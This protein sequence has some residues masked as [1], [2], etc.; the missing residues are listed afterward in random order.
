MLEQLKIFIVLFILV[1]IIDIPVISI[2]FKPRWDK[3][4]KDI[5]GTSL[6]VNMVYAFI[7]YILIPLGLLIFVYPKIDDNKWLEQ[8]IL[9]GFLWGVITYG[10]FD[11]TN[12]GLLSKYPLDLAII[13][14]LWGGILC[15]IVLTITKYIFSK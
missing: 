7:T 11:F 10:I 1:I 2:L 4:I 3:T 15:A 12:L 6:N 9:F 14:T 8:S 5:Q 13:D